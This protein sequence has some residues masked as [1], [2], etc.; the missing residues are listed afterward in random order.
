MTQELQQLKKCDVKNCPLDA[1]FRC[2]YDC[3]DDEIDQT[4]QICKSHYESHDE[5]PSGELFYYF[6]K[7]TKNVE[8]IIH[9]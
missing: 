9:E 6:K 2:T 3:G 8:V 1:D 5:L 7:F 4:I